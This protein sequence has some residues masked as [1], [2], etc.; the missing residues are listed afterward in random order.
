MSDIFRIIELSDDEEDGQKGVRIGI[1]MRVADQDVACPVTRACRCREDL[2]AEVAAIQEQLNRALEAGGA[3]FDRA[4]TQAELQIRPDMP[5]HEIWA[6]LSATEEDD[7][8][9]EQFNTLEEN[10]RRAVAEHVLTQCNVF[11]GKAAL[12]SARYDN[13]TGFMQ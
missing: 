3:V 11:S 1:D 8:L 13:E 12:F 2:K 9:V 10:T 5:A 4:S 6:A 7:R